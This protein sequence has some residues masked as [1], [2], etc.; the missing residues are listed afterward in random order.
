MDLS[1]AQQADYQQQLDDISEKDL[2]L[3]IMVHEQAQS[4]YLEQILAELQGEKRRPNATI[5]EPQSE[6]E[7][8]YQCLQCREI[9]KEE[10]RQKHLTD[11]HNAPAELGVQGEFSKL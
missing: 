11:Q 7:D 4:Q 5:S 1:E 3:E 2:L 8:R 6:S 9:V 10:Q